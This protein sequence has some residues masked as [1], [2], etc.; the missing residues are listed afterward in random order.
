MCSDCD[1]SLHRHLSLTQ[2]VPDPGYYDN[3]SAEAAPCISNCLLCV[4]S[5][6]CLGCGPEYYL[7]ASSLCYSCRAQ[8]TNC[9][10]CSYTGGSVQCSG[11]DNQFELV[12]NSCVGVVCADSNCILCN[13]STTCLQCLPGYILYLGSCFMCA[14]NEYFFAGTCNL[15]MFFIP[16]CI[17]CGNSTDCQQCDTASNYFITTNTMGNSVCTLC[18]IP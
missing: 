2:C 4:N 1:P 8:I 6:S 17:S 16:G 5:L 7:G 12:S 15:C 18:Y 11:C 10:S 13:V 9:S 3:G 14:S